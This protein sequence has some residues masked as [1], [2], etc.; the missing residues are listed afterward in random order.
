MRIIQKFQ[1][2]KGLFE[3]LTAPKKYAQKCRTDAVSQAYLHRLNAHSFARLIGKTGRDG[4]TI[5]S[6]CLQ[7][8]PVGV[9][10]R[11]HQNDLVASCSIDCRVGDGVSDLQISDAADAVFR[12]AV[13]SA[14]ADVAVPAGGG[15]V[16][17]QPL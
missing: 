4:N 3:R 6:G 17:S 16:V 2:V 8:T 11:L 10:D 9:R 14:D 12:A 5:V 1:L 7:I 13:V 15:G